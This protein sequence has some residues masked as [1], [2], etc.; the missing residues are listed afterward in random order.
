MLICLKNGKKQLLSLTRQNSSGD[1]LLSGNVARWKKFANSLRAIAAL[2]LSKVDPAKG[3]TEFAATVADGLL[4]S[5]A[6]NVKYGYLSEANNEHPLYNNYI[7][8]NRKDFAVSSTFVDYLTKVN[9]LACLRLRTK[10]FR[11]LIKE[12]LTGLPSYLDTGCVF[13]SCHCYASTKLFCQCIDLR[14]KCFLLR[15]KPLN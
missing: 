15:Q 12:Y 14:P 10:T 5:N 13:G 11:E 7:T 3:K 8:T 1:I 6:D 4:A 9:D 2:R